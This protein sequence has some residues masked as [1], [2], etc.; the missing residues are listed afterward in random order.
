MSGTTGNIVYARTEGGTLMKQRPLVFYPN[1]PKQ[2]DVARNLRKANW[3]WRG[4]N[5]EQVRRWRNYAASLKSRNPQTG[6]LVAPKAVNVFVGLATKFLQMHPDAPIPLEP[7]E[8]RFLGDIVRVSVEGTS[9]ELVFT[10]DRANAEG[11]V[12]EFLAQR[13]RSMN[14]EPKARS[15]VSAGFLAFD[16]A[17]PEFRSERFP[18]AYACAIRFVESSSGR[19][20]ELLPIG[21]ARVG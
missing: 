12:T 4:L 2:R 15:Y 19:M 9:S 10:G 17:H 5:L 6:L 3:A 8:G 7:P 21:T 1:T 13:L 14:N 18:G 16:D 20:T 11:V